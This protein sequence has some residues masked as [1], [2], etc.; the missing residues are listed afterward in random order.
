MV[1]MRHRWREQLVARGRRATVVVKAARRGRVVGRS[2]WTLLKMKI[3]LFFESH[4]QKLICHKIA[5]YLCPII[6]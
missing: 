1:A 6:K 2:A 3:M 5:Y 4:N